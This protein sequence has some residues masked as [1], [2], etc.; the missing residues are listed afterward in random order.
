MKDNIRY[1]RSTYT[2]RTVQIW[3]RLSEREREN[4]KKYEKESSLRKVLRTH[5]NTKL[6]T[7]L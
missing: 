1:I 3:I 2:V 6:Q 4:R 7:M 5:T